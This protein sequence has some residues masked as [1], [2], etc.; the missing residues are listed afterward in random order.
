[1]AESEVN[2]RRKST[3]RTTRRVFKAYKPQDGTYDEL[4]SAD[5][6]PRAE[7]CKIVEIIDSMEI[8]RAHV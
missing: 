7:F 5:G 4:F 6:T 3:R 8:G 2:A 1:M